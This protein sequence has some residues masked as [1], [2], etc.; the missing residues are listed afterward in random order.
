MIEIIE[1]SGAGESHPRALTD[2]DVNLSAH[3]APIVPL[4]VYIQTASVRTTLAADGLTVRASKPLF[5]VDL[6]TSYTSS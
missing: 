3:P 5:G 4:L 1:S 2:P 6:S